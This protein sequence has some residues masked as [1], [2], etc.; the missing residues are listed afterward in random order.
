[1]ILGADGERLSKRHGA[2][3]VMQYRDDGYLPEAMLNYLARLGWSHGDEEMFTPRAAGRVVRPRAHQPLAGAVQ[4]REAAW[5]NQQYIKARRRCAAG[6][7][8]CSRFLRQ[9]VATLRAPGR[10]SG[11]RGRPAQGACQHR[12]GAGRCGGLFL[13]PAGACRR[14][15]GAAFHRGGEA[16]AC[17]ICGRSLP[18]VEWDKPRHHTTRSRQSRQGTRPEDAARWRCRCA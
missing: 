13:P 6:G 18:T 1:M 15:S 2:V 9:M 7:A 5:L 8:G 16:R 4:S 10:R 3:S 12:G 14:S 17:S 11:E